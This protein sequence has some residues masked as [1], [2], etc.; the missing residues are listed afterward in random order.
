MRAGVLRGISNSPFLKMEDRAEFYLAALGDQ[1]T[2]VRLQAVASI[3]NRMDIGEF[4]G[5]I[6]RLTGLLSDRS[7]EVRNAVARLVTRHSSITTSRK[8]REKLPD[9]YLGRLSGET[10]S[11]RN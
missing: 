6:E 4:P 5:F 3:E 9:L 1:D 7:E 2:S 10:L 8:L 11:Q